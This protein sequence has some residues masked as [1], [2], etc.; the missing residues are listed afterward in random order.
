[1]SQLPECSAQSHNSSSANSGSVDSSTRTCRVGSIEVQDSFAPSSPTS[2]PSPSEMRAFRAGVGAPTCG[3][4]S[5]SGTD[6]SLVTL[7]FHPSVWDAFGSKSSSVA[8]AKAC[9]PAVS[10]PKPAPAFCHELWYAQSSV[11][12][13]HQKKAQLSFNAIRIRPTTAAV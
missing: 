3:S 7:R 6:V 11:G 13:L 8:V 9:S 10:G 2:L 5:V 1:M 4:G 12:E